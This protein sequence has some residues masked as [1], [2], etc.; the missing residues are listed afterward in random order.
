MQNIIRKQSGEIGYYVQ[1]KRKE[2]IKDDTEDKISW[3]HLAHI[4]VL[5]LH[6][7]LH[8]CHLV[9]DLPGLSKW[10]N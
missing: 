1:N 10:Q 6:I 9:F 7:I 5:L 8:C 4:E 2:I 3:S